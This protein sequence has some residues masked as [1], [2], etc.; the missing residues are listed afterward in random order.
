MLLI[1]FLH[2]DASGDIKSGI[3]AVNAGPLGVKPAER[4]RIKVACMSDGKL[5]E[6]AT[7][8]AIHV[9]CPHCQET[10]AFCTAIAAYKKS[11]TV[12]PKKFDLEDYLSSKTQE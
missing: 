9:T 3:P 7:G 11:E 8:E 12:A 5:P 1:H 2:D 4:K 10:P 6:H